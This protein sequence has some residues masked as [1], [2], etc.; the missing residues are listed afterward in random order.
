M[1]SYTVL[2]L[3]K[4]RWMWT[5]NFFLFPWGDQISLII[6]PRIFSR[7][8]YSV[9]NWNRHNSFWTYKRKWKLKNFIYNYI[10]QMQGFSKSIRN[11][12]KRKCRKRKPQSGSGNL[13]NLKK[14]TV[15]K[16]ELK[17]KSKKRSKRARDWTRIFSIKHSNVLQTLLVALLRMK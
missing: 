8:K 2:S 15:I 16:P 12:F 3:I 4:A 10:F 17:K 13:R 1:L 14:I 7:I 5:N 6:R 9:P 11:R